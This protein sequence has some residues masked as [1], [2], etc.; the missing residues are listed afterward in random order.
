MSFLKNDTVSV[1]EIFQEKN[2]LCIGFVM[3]GMFIIVYLIF[4]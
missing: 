4:I 2:N 3:G 1:M